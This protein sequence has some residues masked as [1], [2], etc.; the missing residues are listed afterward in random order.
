MK[1]WQQLRLN[2]AQRIAG[3]SAR[4]TTA[5]RRYSL[6]G[7]S[8]P[9]FYKYLADRA[10]ELRA[11]PEGLALA[12][13]TSVWADRCITT[14]CRAVSRMPWAIYS[15][16]TGD[17]LEN[18]AFHRAYQY[19]MTAFRQNL[20][21]LWEQSLSIHGESYLEKLWN[22]TL[23]GGLRILNAIAVTPFILGGELLYYEYNADGQIVQF[24]PYE[25]IVDLY[26]NA[27]DDFR[28]SSPMTKALDSVNINRNAQSYIKAF[29]RNNATP[30][31][32]L[33]ARDGVVLSD[34]DEAR[35]MEQWAT[36]TKGADNAFSTIFL[37]AS[38]EFRSID[39]KPPE[40]QPQLNEED[41]R[42]ICAAFH[43]PPSMVGA[44]GVSD[45]LSAGGTMDSQKAGFYEAWVIPECDDIALTIND[46]LMPW[47]DPTGDL[48]FEWD[49][50]EIYAL[51][52]QTKER[53][54]KVRAEFKDGAISFNQM[55]IELGYDIVE[56]GDFWL[57]PNN[58]IAVQRDQFTQ[59][60]D[61]LKPQTPGL[62]PTG[63]LGNALVAVPDADK[64]E[65]PPAPVVPGQPS[66]VLMLSFSSHPD[67]IALQNQVRKGQP[68][69]IDWTD[70][71]NFHVTLVYMP[72]ISEA[73]IAAL[74]TALADVEWPQ[75]SLGVGSLRVFKGPGEHAMHFRILRNVALLE[76]QELL[77]DMVA[78]LNIPVSSYS[79]PANYQPHVTIGYSAQPMAEAP[80]RASKIRLVPSALQFAVGETVAWELDETGEPDEADE[81]D[82]ADEQGE[83]PQADAQK[84]L[85]AWEKKVKNSGPQKAFTTY[86]IRAEIADA[87]RAALSSAGDDRLHVKAAFQSAAEA[88]QE[89]AH[90]QSLFRAVTT[91][92]IKAYDDTRAAFVKEMLRIIGAGQQEEVTRR[93]FAGEMRSA[94]RRYG[95]M[96][97]R[98]GMNTVDYDPE[99]LSPDELLTFRAWQEEQSGYVA[100]LG[101]EVFKQG[102]TEAEVALRA[103]LWANVSLQAIYY[104]GVAAGKGEQM[105][106]WKLGDSEESC[107]DCPRLDGNVRPMK[108]WLKI[109]LFPGSGRT[110]CKLGCKCSLKPTDLPATKNPLPI[111]VGKNV[112]V[113]SL[114]ATEV[115]ELRRWVEEM[116]DTF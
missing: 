110:E 41:R 112:D 17:K 85:A 88:L 115:E 106:V 21:F 12:A 25:L 90:I 70:P 80:F 55:Q 6:G 67:L 13:E 92:P 53:S 44:A 111:V 52:R 10:K 50:S 59:I 94:L 93:K 76:F 97:F 75:L 64:A 104:E 105:M 3:R 91:T 103:N 43:V 63:G 83:P 24:Q 78:G 65:P 42:G 102:I 57:M 86:H 22:G 30:G 73:Q 34:D 56:G 66:G 5:S 60:A 95:L 11:D 47:L 84:E 72:S 15:K 18:T 46:S 40:Y 101:A 82:E 20:F 2:L 38:V 109:K 1:G 23:P 116:G 45:P 33:T 81:E 4:V 100:G 8:Y 113:A 89:D 36:Q 31:G 87:L 26:P 9:G 61:L 19:A 48:L 39:N 108:Y 99:S 74:T 54:D 16:S 114:K 96:A 69:G 51:T 32:F 58:V 98:D 49:Y 68:P 37:P 14:R 107:D 35:L 62:L 28:G 71:A 7:G 77:Y 29:Y 27:L 79:F